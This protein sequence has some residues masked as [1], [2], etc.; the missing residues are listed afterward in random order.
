MR[1]D[2][3]S[4]L[5]TLSSDKSSAGA[6]LPSASELPASRKNQFF[7]IGKSRSCSL[8]IPCEHVSRLHLTIRHDGQG[9]YSVSSNSKN[10]TVL[11]DVAIDGRGWV[12]LR[13]HDVIGV[14]MNNACGGVRETRPCARA[15]CSY[16][17]LF[18]NRRKT[19]GV[20]MELRIK[21]KPVFR[22]RSLQRRLYSYC[23]LRLK[24]AN[25]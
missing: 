9:R 18:V 21:S 25:D 6:R 7:T 12:P 19:G 15:C 13:H 24:K 17:F 22:R 5:V 20:G 3:V 23:D 4:T 16:T 2:E 11:N 8:K 10:G 14:S 1:D